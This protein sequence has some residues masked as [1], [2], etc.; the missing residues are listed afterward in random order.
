MTTRQGIGTVITA[1]QAFTAHGRA[2]CVL[3]PT[4][5]RT[6]VVS[7]RTSN[8]VILVADAVVSVI[9]GLIFLLW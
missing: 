3:E 1:I 7:Q 8:G 9:K 2:S 4:D 6:M 5:P